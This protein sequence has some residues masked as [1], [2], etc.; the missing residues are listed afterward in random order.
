M[1]SKDVALA[2]LDVVKELEEMSS[3]IGSVEKVLFDRLES[4]ADN[5]H[6]FRMKQIPRLHEVYKAH[7]AAGFTEE[8]SMLLIINQRAALQQAL[9]RQA[10][11]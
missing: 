8:Q 2:I 3:K 7:V 1:D 5:Y 6:A 4:L 11:K 9:E 10:K